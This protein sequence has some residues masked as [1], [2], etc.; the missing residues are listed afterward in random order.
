[1]Q[2]VT[3]TVIALEVNAY[4]PATYMLPGGFMHD[5]EV[6]AKAR[7]LRDLVEVVAASVYFLVEAH[8]EYKE[9][10]LPDF[11]PAYFTSRGACMGQVPGEVVTAAFGVF[12]PAIV[13]P[14]VDEGWAKTDRESILGARERGAVDGL[15]RLLGPSPDGMARA[16]EILIRGGDAATGEGRGL[17]SG[18]RSLGF[19]GTPMGDFWRASDLVR[20]HRGDSHI[21]AWVAYGL[22]PIQATLST[23]LWWRMP[24]KT[25]VRTRGWSDE[26]IDA[27]LDD[28]R[29]RGLVDGDAFSEKGE[30]LR[31]DIELSTDRQERSIVEAIGDDFEELCM[32]LSPMKDAIVAGG[33]YPRDPATMTRP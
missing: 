14:A 7:K 15:T 2:T 6:R 16:T 20:E 9:L 21:I 25:Y 11:G 4:T 28:L 31:G 23:E 33:G 18:L 32:I 24:L 30:E 3:D 1:M 17:Y 12:N 26:Q 27:A 19:P 29:V 8:N 10:G 5:E 13:I 22:D